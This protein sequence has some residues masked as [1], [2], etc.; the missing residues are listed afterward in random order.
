M[1]IMWNCSSV[2]NETLSQKSPENFMFIAPV[3]FNISWLF[4]KM[5]YSFIY[6]DLYVYMCIYIRRLPHLHLYNKAIITKSRYKF[7]FGQLHWSTVITTP[8]NTTIIVLWWILMMCV[9]TMILI[10]KMQKNRLKI[11]CRIC[12]V[13]IFF[14]ILYIYMYVF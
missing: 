2:H 4:H 1:K 13:S 11:Y 3:V 9:Y 7:L 8:G 10:S 14:L 12:V 5:G 6:R